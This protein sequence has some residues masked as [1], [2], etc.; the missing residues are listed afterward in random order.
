MLKYQRIDTLE[1]AAARKA[2]NQP[3]F[4]PL[5][6]AAVLLLAAIVPGV[7]GYRRRERRAAV[8]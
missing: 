5:A 4:W 1:R 8:K 3:V 2:W 7:L 6:V